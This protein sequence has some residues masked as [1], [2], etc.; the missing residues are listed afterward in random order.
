MA[1]LMSDYV[2]TKHKGLF[3]HKN[4]NNK[5]VANF[6][7]NGKATRKTFTTSSVLSKAD[8]LKKAYLWFEE[9]KNVKARVMM[10]GADENST[11]DDYFN[12][13]QEIS[14]R[15]EDTKKS[16]QLY[17]DKYIK[18]IIGKM[19]IINVAPTHIS[20]ITAST[21]H[22]SKSSKQKMMTILTPIFK[23]AIDEEIIQFSPI[24]Q[25]HRVKR[26]QLEE[27]KIITNAVDKYRLVHQA[28]MTVFEDNPKIRAL[29]LFGF[30]GRRKTETLKLKWSDIDFNTDE[31]IIRSDNS[32]IN[33]DMTFKLSIDVK[34]ALLECEHFS[35]YVFASNRDP[36][37]PIS[38]IR[39]HVA[40]IK[41]VTVPEYNFHWM[42]NLAV[43]ALSSMGVSAIDL[44]ALLGHTDTATVQQYLSL[45][46][47]HSTA[48]TLGVSQKLLKG[49]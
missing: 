49:F 41:K 27:K 12:R 7:I 11:I 47:E 16:Y 19:K 6:K 44:S 39:E 25:T 21:H 35:E 18:P 34:K 1:I 20:K 10:S 31:F 3:V 28:I 14:E 42:R 36:S 22:L 24:K 46:R 13:L 26:K 2:K 5:F 30:H 4:N 29:F 33:S 32:K 17:Y 8:K 38:E 43:S 9:L 15:N 48:I 45:Q 37:K 23:L 40:K